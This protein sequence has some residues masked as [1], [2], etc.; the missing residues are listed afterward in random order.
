M[1]P[2]QKY[3]IIEFAGIGPGPFCGMLLSDMGAEVI[4]IDR[5]D[6]KEN[7]NYQDI[8]H[9]GRRSI[10]IDLKQ[11][12]GLAIVR[13]LIENADA[14]LEG[15][16]PGVMEK[17]GLGPEDCLRLN[18]RLVYG[19]VT[20]WGQYGCLANSAGHDINY[21]AVT[22]AL[23][24]VGEKGGAP[25]PPINLVG[26]FGGG[27][28]LLALGITAALL[29]VQHSGK[30]QVVDAAMTDG[31]ALLMSMMYGFKSMG[32]WNNQR[33]CN[34]LDGGAPFYGTYKCSDGKWIAIGSIEPQFYQLLLEKTKISTK[35]FNTQWEQNNWSALKECLAETFKTKTRDEWCAIMENTDVCF[36]P[37]LDMDEAPEYRHNKD[38]KTFLNID[39]VIQPAPAPRFSRTISEIQSPPA[40]RGAHTEDILKQHGY[41]PDDIN[42]LK[43]NRV[44]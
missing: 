20:G 18:P 37:V 15:F 16:R 2:L 35:W 30:G 33:G 32:M 27:G 3:R 41:S 5:L 21:I 14:L 29:D 24:G 4:C 12:D 39:G 22:G 17:L 43:Q 38:R 11:P 8:L 1:G 44:I 19:R 36:A 25:I 31:S 42:M 6:T 9:R 40:K 13:R 28:M 10:T 23:N 34:F 26:D 7:S